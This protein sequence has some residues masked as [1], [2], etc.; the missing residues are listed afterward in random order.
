MGYKFLLLAFSAALLTSCSTY[1]AGQTPDDVYYSPAREVVAKQQKEEKRDRYEEYVSSEDDRYLRMKIRN[2]DR[3]STI[4]DYTYW[5]DSRYFDCNSIYAYNRYDY[6][7]KYNNSYLDNYRTNY[8]YNSCVSNNYYRTN[9]FGYGGFYSPRY[10]V[11]YYKSP[12]VYTG[13]T[14]KSNLS[15]YRNTNYNNSNYNYGKGS[16]PA[17]FGT[18]MKRVFSE[19]NNSNGNNTG[20]SSWERP[21][22]TVDPG[23]STN[24]NAGGKSGGYNSSGSSTETKRGPR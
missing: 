3:W 10:P 12:K 1:K 4:D 19:S 24:S 11:V 7:N 16:N 23:T 15:S 5:N 20:S 18:L 6:Y 14:G 22:R 9:Y 17:S 2:R 8:M 21:V 13:N